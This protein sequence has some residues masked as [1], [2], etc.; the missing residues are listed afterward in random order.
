MPEIKLKPCPFCGGEAEM[1]SWQAHINDEYHLNLVCTTCGAGFQDV[2]S[3]ED[4]L[5][6]WNRRADTNEH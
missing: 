4:A 6:A 1:F 2:S 3:K 5:K